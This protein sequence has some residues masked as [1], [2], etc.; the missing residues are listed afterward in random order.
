MRRGDFTPSFYFKIMEY[1]VQ[2]YNIQTG[3]SEEFIVEDYESESDLDDIQYQAYLG[4]TL[5][6]LFEDTKQE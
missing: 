5:M 3:K 6:G 2:V 4:S 1:R